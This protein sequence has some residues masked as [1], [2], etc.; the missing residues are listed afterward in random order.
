MEIW[1]EGTY[2]PLEDTDA[3]DVSKVL[4]AQLEKGDLKFI[5]KGKHLKGAF[6]L[7]QMKGETD[8]NWLLIKKKDTFSVKEFDIEKHKPVKPY[9]KKKIAKGSERIWHADVKKAGKARVKKAPA[10]EKKIHEKKENIHDVWHKLQKPMLAKLTQR[11]TNNPDWIYEV[12]YDGYRAITKIDNGK[13]QMLSRNGNSFNKQY[14]SLIEE[15]ETISDELIIDGEIV[16]ENKKGISDFQLLQNYVRSKKG[17]LSYYVFD[18][19][20]VNG[21]TI[22]KLPLLQRKELLETLFDNYTFRHIINSKFIPEKGEELFEKLAAKGYE[23]IIAKDGQSDY[24]PGKRGDSWLKVKSVMEQEAIICGY[25]HPQNSRKY[26]GSLLLGLQ[27]KNKLV[28]IGN[29]GTGFTETSLKEL[30]EQFEKIRAAK[31]PF[32]EEPILAGSKGK[33]VWLKPKL[34]CNVKFHEWTQDEHMR[35]PVFMGLRTDKKPVEVLNET[36]EISIDHKDM[37]TAVKE[38]EKLVLAGK[39]E[40]K[41]TN[42]NKIYWPGEGIT[43]GDLINYYQNISKYILPY[44]KNRPQSLNR[45]PN[46]IKGP[47]FYQKDMDVEK[48]PDWVKTFKFHSKSTGKNIDYLLC[49]DEAT[50]VYMANLGCIEINPWHS[51]YTAPDNPDYMML[52]L[53]PGD[54]GFVHVVDTALVIKEICDEIKVDSFCKTSGATGLHIY[55]PLGGKYD[56]DD[57]KLFAIIIYF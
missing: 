22:I 34:V 38:T 53:D 48:L 57:I 37:E 25:T 1:D 55:I 16:I 30:H 4:K 18:L 15:L 28:Y 33:V 32:D 10:P 7:V 51:K 19:L 35:V 39:I 56:Y 5:L 43:K 47:S 29:C 45:H 36:K 11:I 46:G 6:A 9:S 2:T 49:N 31:S 13:V 40:I 8:K 3:K 27:K 14:A 54:I 42:I 12:K 23:G 20:F 41:C 26:F 24:L 50:L 44:L 17:T 21:H 52:D